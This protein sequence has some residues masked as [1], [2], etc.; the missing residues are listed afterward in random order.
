MTPKCG[1]LEQQSATVEL[2]FFFCCC[3]FK[4]TPVWRQWGQPKFGTLQSQCL[5]PCHHFPYL[6]EKE[7]AQTHRGPQGIPSCLPCVRCERKVRYQISCHHP[8]SATSMSFLFLC[9]VHSMILTTIKTITKIEYDK[10]EYMWISVKCWSL[11]GCVF[12]C[13]CEQLLAIYLLWQACVSVE[14]IWNP[15]NI[16]ARSKQKLTLLT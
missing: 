14:F 10:H 8:K 3:F 16:T 5:F 15:A 11:S 4:C 2:L 13:I 12:A 6:P 9:V 1:H 7:Q